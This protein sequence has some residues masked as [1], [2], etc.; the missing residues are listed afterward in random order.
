MRRRVLLCLLLLAACSGRLDSIHASGELR[1]GT[2]GD[3]PPFTYYD[4]DTKS[5]SGSD[6][7]VARALARKMGVRPIFVPTT[8]KTL[9]GDMEA[10]RFDIAVGGISVTEARER[11]GMFSLPY[12]KDGK[13]AVVRCKD[14]RRYDTPEAIDRPGVRAV[15]NPGGTNEAFARE[16]LSRASLR[17]FPD[18]TRIF[19]EIEEGRADVMITDLAE[20]RYQASRSVGRLCAH[21]AERPFTTSWKAYFLAPDA[22]LR[23]RVNAW[24]ME[25]GMAVEE[26]VP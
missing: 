18:N 23:D 14:K 5:Y 19:K 20:A 25:R 17:V 21:G 10:G 8:W 3:Y 12:L 7:E 24:L 4:A 22:A 6:I 11:V 9:S 16:R 1:I 2:T 13:V 15:V 26:S